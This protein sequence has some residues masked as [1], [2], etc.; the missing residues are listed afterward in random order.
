MSKPYSFRLGENETDIREVLEP[1]SGRERSSFIRAALRFYIQ[2]GEEIFKISQ[3]IE[4]ILVRMETGSLSTAPIVMEQD[5]QAV[6]N[7][8][9]IIFN[10]IQ[11]LLNL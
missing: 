8:D 3:G 1:M 4:N 5:R 2:F 9:E 6:S 11:E 10:S 7:D